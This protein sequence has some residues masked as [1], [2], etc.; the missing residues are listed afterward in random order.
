MLGFIGGALGI[1]L[2]YDGLRLLVAIGP[3]NLPRL[4]E[5]SLDVRALGFTA[6][7]SLFSGLLFGLIRPSGMADRGFQSL[8]GP[9]VGRRA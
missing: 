7:L 8:S 5:I 9:Q 1:R 6:F 3:A 2:V 4:S